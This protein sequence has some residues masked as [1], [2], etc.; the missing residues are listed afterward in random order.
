MRRRR[1]VCGNPAK[2][3]LEAFSSRQR[4]N[5]FVFSHIVWSPHGSGFF[6]LLHYVLWKKSFTDHSF[7]SSTVKFPFHWGNSIGGYV[8]IQKV[9]K[10]QNVLNFHIWAY[11]SCPK[12]TSNTFF[13]IVG[14]LFNLGGRQ[15][16]DHRFENQK[17]VAN[18]LSRFGNGFLH[19][20]FQSARD[21]VA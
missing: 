11:C 17:L 10:N 13:V 6:E 19:G 14:Y 15:V 12:I 9:P 8:G 7:S 21:S 2:A 20:S 1:T 3:E 16:V 5:P 4:K 18:L